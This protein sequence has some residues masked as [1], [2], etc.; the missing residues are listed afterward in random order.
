MRS[1]VIQ[2]SFTARALRAVMRPW[3]AAAALACVGASAFA[4]NDTLESIDAVELDVRALS[5]RVERLESQVQPGRGFISERQAL[6]RY[7]EYVYL[8]MVGEYTLAAE[9]FFTLVTTAALGD[10]GLHRDAEWYLA[11]S[12]FQMGNVATAEAR[13]LVIANDAQHPFREDAVRR[14]LELYATTSQAE[15]FDRYYRQEILNGRVRPSDLITYSLARSFY[16]QEKYADARVHYS[17]IQPESPYYARAQYSVGALDVLAGDLAAAKERFLPI[18]QL[19]VESYQDRQV[20]DLALLAM[21]RILYEEGEFQQASEYYSRVSGDSEYQADQLYEMVWTYIEQEEFDAALD[22]VEIFLIRYPEH[23]YTAQLQ[24]LQGH[25]SMERSRFEAALIAYEGVVIDY[26][27]IRERMSELA[28][29]GADTSPYFEHI[30]SAEETGMYG[31]EGLPGYAYAMMVADPEVSRAIEVYGDL[32][33]Q[34]QQIESSEALIEELDQVLGSDVGLGGFEHLRY[35]LGIQQERAME[36]TLDLLRVEEEWVADRASGVDRSAIA[37]L[38]RR[39][40]ALKSRMETL[41]TDLGVEERRRA[42]QQYF[43]ELSALEAQVASLQEEAR[44]LQAAIDA[45]PSGPQSARYGIDLRQV[46]SDLDDVLVATEEL[47]SVGPRSEW[48]EQRF[49]SE[50]A[51]AD[52]VAALRRELRDMRRSVAGGDADLIASR[53]DGLHGTLEYSLERMSTLRSQLSAM[54]SQELSRIRVRFEHEVKEVARQRETYVDTLVDAESVSADLTRR[55]FG[56][57][58]DFFADS[59]LRADMGIVDVYWARTL[60]VVD[61][62]RRVAEEKAALLRDLDMRFD[63]IRQKLGQR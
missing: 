10:A 39:R 5:D 43:E 59:I 61:Q 26:G 1:D 4:A 54:E 27:P 56:R 60:D 36:R 63:I 53:L 34:K 23:Q 9:G 18:T 31:A 14:L 46:E 3:L 52:D 21:G 11:E 15:K 57:L 45:D 17:E 29:S 38:T 44:E 35:A 42:R 48:E 55:G 30:L 28:T 6:E 50:Q 62:R 22:A 33:R 25:L 41:A 20:L 58:E 37:D 19:S 8:H 51:M 40:E 16:L 13:Y 49:G 32:E 47:R 2:T 7:R 12:L 24:L